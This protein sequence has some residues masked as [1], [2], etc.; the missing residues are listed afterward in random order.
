MYRER[1][2]AERRHLLTRFL[3]TQHSESKKRMSAKFQE[4]D[5]IDIRFSM[6]IKMMML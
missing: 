5:E 2:R 4:V 3:T 1:E 6:G